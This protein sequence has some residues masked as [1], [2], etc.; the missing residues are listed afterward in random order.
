MTAGAHT[1]MRWHKDSAARKMSALHST[2]VLAVS[3]GAEV[4]FWRRFQGLG[5]DT[6]Q[7]ERLTSGLPG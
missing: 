2:C 7:S 3:Q 6:E 4:R 1:L 5:D